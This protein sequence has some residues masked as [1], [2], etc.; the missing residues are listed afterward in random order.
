[1][2]VIRRGMAVTM[3]EAILGGRGLVLM[4]VMMMVWLTIELCKI[5]GGEIVVA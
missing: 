1:V 4:I 3:P 2:N 5:G